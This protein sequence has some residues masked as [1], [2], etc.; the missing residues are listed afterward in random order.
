MTVYKSEAIFQGS[1]GLSKDQWV[2]TWYFTGAPPDD[3]TGN[4]VLNSIAGWIND[5]YVG[6]TDPVCSYMSADI[7]TPFTIKTYDVSDPKPRPI[8]SLHQPTVVVD[9]TDHVMPSEV[10]LCLSFYATRN[11]PKQRGRIYLGPLSERAMTVGRISVPVAGLL[12]SMA[13]AATRLIHQAAA[14]VHTFTDDPLALPTAG[15]LV[16]WVN[17]SD[18]G[19]TGTKA[20]PSPSYENITN[21]WIDNE[22]DTVRRRREKATARTLYS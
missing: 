11:V 1:S 19:V 21:G 2:N 9:L 17:H 13:A 4:Q 7:L 3:P 8:R 16:N 15:H 14:P 5:F 12:T 6:G 20:V 22:W 18:I 10:A